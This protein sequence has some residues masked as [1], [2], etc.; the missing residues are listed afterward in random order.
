MRDR[1]LR[2][3]ILVAIIAAVSFLIMIF[4]FALPVFPPFLKLDFSD[5]PALL[6]GFG[7]GPMAGL[8]VVF[9]RKLLHLTITA[10]MG[11]GELANF[12]ISGSFVFIS[13]YI[14]NKYKNQG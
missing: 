10:T 4:E 2:T 1:K 11:I 9:M 13:D 8:G 5:L 3:A 14:F 7:L 12:I 6:I